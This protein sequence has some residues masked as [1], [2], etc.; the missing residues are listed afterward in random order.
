[1]VCC[2][3]WIQRKSTYY[4]LYALAISR[5][6]MEHCC[7]FTLCMW[8]RMVTDEKKPRFIVYIVSYYYE[9]I[10]VKCTEYPGR[11]KAPGSCL[12]STRVR[13]P[14]YS[15]LPSCWDVCTMKTLTLSMP[16]AARVCAGNTDGALCAQ[17]HQHIGCADGGSHTSTP[18]ERGLQ[19]VHDLLFWTWKGFL[20][21]IFL[22][23][24]Y[25]RI[26]QSKPA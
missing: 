19:P 17:N 3:A 16:R 20:P 25:Q 6:D 9:W 4:N 14:E 24:Y 13:I 18:H 2:D 7:C 22:W 21:F 10:N 12:R 1:M 15:F 26:D 5:K 8:P 23:F 11:K